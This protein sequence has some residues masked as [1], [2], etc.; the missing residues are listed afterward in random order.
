MEKTQGETHHQNPRRWLGPLLR[1]ALLHPHVKWADPGGHHLSAPPTAPHQAEPTWERGASTR[2][3]HCPPGAVAV[4]G[5]PLSAQPLG[6]DRWT[7]P[8]MTL[9]KV[10]AATKPQ[11]LL[12]QQ[13][14][15]WGRV[16][17]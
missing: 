9:L 6:P 5:I 3:P 10:S 4:E 1:A 14:H 2:R 8:K 17:G 7:R 15:C 11:C 13:G 16:R 12:L